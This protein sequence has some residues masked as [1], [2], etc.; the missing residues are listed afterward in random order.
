MQVLTVDDDEFMLRV[1]DQTLTR[2]GYAAVSAHDGQAA[3][4]ILRR[5]DIR[6]VITDWEMAPVN[7]IDLCRSIRRQDLSGYIYI[8]MLTGREGA[9]QRIEG[10]CAGADAFLTKPLDPEELLASLKGAERI[11]ALET[12]DVALLA[13]TKLA[14][15]RDPETGAHVERVQNYSRLIAS[16]LSPEFKSANGVNDDYVRLIHQTSPLHDIGKISIP[17]SILLKAGSLTHAEFELIKTHTLVGERTLETALKRFPDADFLKFARQI[18]AS[19]HENFDGTGYPRG[20]SGS[21][22]PLCARIVALADTY[23][24]LTSERIYKHAGSHEQAKSIILSERGKKFDPNVIE[25]FLNAESQILDVCR[26]L[27]ETALRAAAPI[28]IPEAPTPE[29]R[30]PHSCGIL[31]VDDDPDMVRLIKHFL[32][33]TGETIHTAADGREALRVLDEFHPRVIVSDWQMPVMNGV[34]FCRQIRQRGNAAVEHI[35]ML[36]ATYNKERLQ[37]AYIAGVDDFV[38]KP[39]QPEELLARVR[40]GIRAA[41]LRDELADKEAGSR[42]RAAQLALANTQL[43]KLSVIDDLTGLFNRRHA[44]DRLT[45]QWALAERGSLSHPLAIAAF[46]IDHFKKINDT[47]GHDAGDLVLRELATVISSTKRTPDIFCRVGGE[48]FLL[49]FPSQSATE[50]RACAERCRKAVE[51]HTFIASGQQ[52]KVTISVGVASRA[53]GMTQMADLLKVADQLLYA[54]K[55]AGRNQVM[56]AEELTTEPLPAGAPPVD[57]NAVLKRCGGDPKFA[58]AVA[59]RFRAQAPNELAQI[60]QAVANGDFET[61]HHV[62]HRLKSMAAYMGADAASEL[63]RQLEELGREGQT[64]E[65]P[66]LSVRLREEIVSVVSFISESAKSHAA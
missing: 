20:L 39:F 60:E 64:T 41:K 44:M 59:A 46:D 7:G 17:D 38:P 47:Y 49:I 8:I 3:M 24:G 1:L 6:L 21:A 23:D 31:I 57:L 58:A 22:I 12:R 55:S 56:I 16:N 62:A 5:G 13:M 35:I 50:S 34:E 15:S 51:E 10:L 33:A 37:E 30:V 66:R 36:T 32:A 63:C 14:E 65:M 45:E 61:V 19:H 40:A 18:A 11:L 54:A 27:S 2:M 43:E 42:Q 29:E 25:A 28:A 53:R 9:R 26:R 4:E 48:E 52:I